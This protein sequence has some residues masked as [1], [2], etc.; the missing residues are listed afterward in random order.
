MPLR[1]CTSSHLILFDPEKEL[2]M[3]ILAHCNYNLE[4]GKSTKLEYDFTN[5]EHQI[6]DQFIY[7][8]PRIKPNVKPLLNFSFKSKLTIYCFL[9]NIYK[10][11]GRF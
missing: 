1:E 4:P 9:D 5:L 7:D 8:K 6:M 10:L 11:H 3:L 2:H